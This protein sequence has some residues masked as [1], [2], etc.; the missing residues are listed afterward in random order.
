MTIHNYLYHMKGGHPEYILKPYSGLIIYK[1]DGIETLKV[2]KWDEHYFDDSYKFNLLGKYYIKDNYNIMLFA[3]PLGDGNKD[4]EE[5]YSENRININSN[6]YKNVAQ[7]L[8][9]FINEYHL[10]LLDIKLKNMVTIDGKIKFIDLDFN[11]KVKDSIDDMDVNNFAKHYYNR[12]RD[13]NHIK[14]L[15]PRD[16]WNYIAPEVRIPE[17]KINQDITLTWNIGWMLY[18]DLEVIY[19][20]CEKIIQKN[21]KLEPLKGDTQYMLNVLLLLDPAMI[22]LCDPSIS[23]GLS[24]LRD[25]GVIRTKQLLLSCIVPLP[26]KDDPAWVSGEIYRNWNPNNEIRPT[27]SQLI[28]VLQ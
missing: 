26:G 8:L 15:V 18:N 13:C 27:L 22:S 2:Y 4:I 7:Y 11:C 20:K 19:S 9:D 21:G 28:R 12:L 14:S 23:D 5:L 17:W 16:K 1:R 10:Y 24:G 3:M 6:F 25:D